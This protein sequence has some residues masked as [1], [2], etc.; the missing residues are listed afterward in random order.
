MLESKPL[1]T[2]ITYCYNGEAFIDKYFEA[3]LSQTY[4]NIELIF[5][6]NGSEDKTG[7]IIEKYRDKLKHKGIKFILHNLEKNNP[8]TCELKQ[9]A[10][11][12][13]NGEYFFGCDSDD[14]I[15]PNYIEKMAGYLESHPEK[16]MVI[17]QLNS[18]DEN[19][20]VR[21]LMKANPQTKD[22]GAFEDIIM[23]RN[24]LYTAVSYMM[25][26]KWMDKINPKREIYLSRFGENYQCQ[27]PFLYHNLQGYIEEVL[28]QYMVRSNSYSGTLTSEKK[29]ISFGGQEQTIIETLKSIPI[30]EFD[31]Y[32]LMAK[33]RLRRDKFY[34]ALNLKDK[35][36]L[37]SCYNELKELDACTFREKAIFSL[38]K[39]RYMWELLLK[40]KNG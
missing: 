12:E 23:A 37:E 25:S 34:V 38:C 13:M 27:M 24:T 22:K 4:S 21:G 40:V 29:I 17:C 8:F 7:E 39:S 31:Y 2:M 19:Y 35:S 26:T 28:G 15:L 3:V 18:V 14:I 33:K 30:E 5:F 10:F 6:N 11:Q 9:Q 1:V 16:G 36:I 20:N 32:S